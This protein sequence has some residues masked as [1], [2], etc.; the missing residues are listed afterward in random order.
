VVLPDPPFWFKMATIMTCD[1]TE[2]RCRN[3][4]IKYHLSR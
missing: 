3:R 4:V 2:V 1:Y